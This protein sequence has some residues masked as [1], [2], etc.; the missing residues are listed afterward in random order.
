METILQLKVDGTNKGLCD[1]WQSIQ[2]L[3][4]IEEFISLNVE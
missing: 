4:E 2:V 3:A 1:Q